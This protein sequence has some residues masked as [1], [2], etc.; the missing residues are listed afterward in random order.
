MAG[1]IVQDKY[2]KGCYYVDG[3]TW[4]VGTRYTLKRVL[5]CGSFS[6]VVSALD[7]DTHEQVALK[8]IPDVLANAENAKRVLREVCILRRLAHPHIIGLKDVFLKPSST[9]RYMYKGGQLVPT[10]L[11]LYLALEYC[12]QGDLFHLKG[13]LSEAEVKVMMLQLLS[14]VQYLHANGVWH[15]DIKS[16]NILMTYTSGARHIKLADLGSARSVLLEQ[17]L[18]GDSMTG[19]PCCDHHAAQL[20]QLGPPSSSP[21]K[22]SAAAVAAAEAAAAVQAALVSASTQTSNGGGGGS[23]SSSGGGGSSSSGGDGGS[24]RGGGGRRGLGRRCGRRRRAQLALARRVAEAHALVLLRRDLALHLRLRLRHRHRLAARRE[25]PGV[26]EGVDDHAPAVAPEHVGRGDGGRAAI[27]HSA[28]H[29]PVH[30]WDVSVHGHRALQALL[31]QRLGAGA[32]GFVTQHEH[33]VPDLHL[34]MER[35]ARG[36]G[37]RPFGCGAERGL[38]EFDGRSGRLHGEDGHDSLHCESVKLIA[39]I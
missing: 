4:Q 34:T 31:L 35:L 19:G 22:P 14:A 27:R 17:T 9:G 38:V 16:A 23:S 6:S 28:R 1:V 37:E 20:Q 7:N 24:S 36:G 29:H 10:S 2:D 8:R 11:E 30:V 26:P 18:R 12:D 5:G 39:A 21:V 33:G 13:Q 3:Q 15:R 25:A 32:P